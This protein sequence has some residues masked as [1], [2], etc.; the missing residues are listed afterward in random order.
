MTGE[1]GFQG[2]GKIFSITFQPKKIGEAKIDFTDAE[3]LAS[4]GEGT[5]IT[6]GKSG[7]IYSI[8]E[9]KQQPSYDFNDDNKV[10]IVDVSIL[11]SHW[12]SDTNLQYDLNG[13]GKVDLTD[14]SILISRMWK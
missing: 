10:N 5:D 1:I 11:V 14:L 4:D 8:I 13:N 3:I 6:A 7:V 2:L 9:T 12:N